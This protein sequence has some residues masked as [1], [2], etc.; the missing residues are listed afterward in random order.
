MQRGMETEQMMHFIV[1]ASGI[2]LMLVSTLLLLFG[3]YRNRRNRHIIEKQI[4]ETTF[5]HNMLQARLEIQE[6]TFNAISQEI[7][8]NVGQLLSLAK[9]QLSI[10]EQYETF[11][12]SLLADIKVNVSNALN[13]L[14]DIA[15]SLNSDR[16]RQLTLYQIVDEELLRISRWSTIRY[17]IQTIG[18]ERPIDEQRKSI[19]YRIVQECLQNTLKH[20]NATEISVSLN[21]HPS[22]LQVA[23][24]DNGRGFDGTHSASQPAGIGLTNIRARTGSLGGSVT[25]DSAPEKGTS[26]ILIVPYA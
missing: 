21:Y 15:R 9:V 20:A 13:D 1:I 14:R 25:I 8:D 19:L 5:E 23:I 17:D 10:A 7:H 16:I 18:A 12:K 2:L 3:W 24:S 26:V 11:D 6:Q 4:M 22:T